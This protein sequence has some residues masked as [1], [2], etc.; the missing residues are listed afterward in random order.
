MTGFH[1]KDFHNKK[2]IDFIH[3]EDQF[4]VTQRQSKRLRGESP[5]GLSTVRL[6]SKS[7]EFVWVQVSA[8][9]IEWGGEPATLNFLT[10]ITA[11]KNAELLIQNTE[12]KFINLFDNMTSGVAVY[13]VVGEGQ[14]FIFADMNNAG[15]LLSQIKIEDVRGKKIS[16]VFPSVKDMGLFSVLQEVWTT[17]IPNSHPLTLYKDD[18]ISQWVENQVYKLSSGQ[19]MAI[20]HDVTAQ[21]KSE[22]ALRET[23]QKY[24][25]IFNSASELM[26]SV[27]KKGIITGWN[28]SAERLTGH[29]S[30]DMIGENLF[31]NPEGLEELSKM[32]RVS[33]SKSASDFGDIQIKSKEE[34]QR[35][36][37]S[38]T[39]LVRDSEGKI[40]GLLLVGRD[41][42]HDHFQY[43]KIVKGCAYLVTPEEKNKVLNSFRSFMDEGYAGL[44]ITREYPRS[45]N[46]TF[47]GSEILWLTSAKS[48]DF[49]T[50]SDKNTILAWIKEK[51][52][53]HAKS[54]VFFDRLDYLLTLEGFEGVIKTI[55]LINDSV[56]KT[57][58]IAFVYADQSFMSEQQMKL[59]SLELKELP[60]P[61]KIDI[62]V[63][64]RQMEILRYISNKNIAFMDV[65]FKDISKEFNI[66]K[67]TTKKILSSLA[68]K[69]LIGVKKK[70]RLKA[71]DLT[72]EGKNILS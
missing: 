9:V 36:L 40:D 52:K 32:I 53:K 17:G 59:L 56:M 23:E 71:L 69:A 1:E 13:D 34:V 65:Y 18:R 46:K 54:V 33:L 38:S 26:I 31:E 60:F 29:K 68:G 63:S 22:E 58:N 4:E 67:I 21:K 14:D 25:L 70:G 51:I 30:I 7:G 42:S 39:S 64:E 35:Y 66:S 20:Y 61:K 5:L 24:K 10:D 12:Q 50:A 55:Y 45:Y 47:E 43:R 15:Q 41:V 48:L 37:L 19:I 62:K 44:V 49:Q 8:A 57:K 28:N 27:D 11:M 72:E 6:L 2:F 16:E 3:H